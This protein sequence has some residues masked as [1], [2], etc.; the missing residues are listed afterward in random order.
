VSETVSLSLLL[1]KASEKHFVP[2]SALA[3][4]WSILSHINEKFMGS[5]FSWSLLHV[6][7][8]CTVL[9]RLKRDQT[10]ET[11]YFA[12]ALVTCSPDYAVSR[13]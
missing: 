12:W 6:A 8:L 5:C 9:L 10:S 4:S 13:S 2:D 3:Q 1:L 11:L 7:E